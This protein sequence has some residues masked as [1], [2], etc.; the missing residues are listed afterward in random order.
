MAN[1]Y[2]YRTDP[3]FIKAPAP[4]QKAYLMKVDPDFAKAAPS[5]QAKYLSHIKGLDQPTRFEQARTGDKQGFLSA[6][7]SD[8]AG[9]ASAIYH[10]P[11][12]PTGFV[13]G[14]AQNIADIPQHEREQKAAGRSL[15]YRAVAAAGQAIGVPTRAM[16]QAADVGDRGAV[17]GHAVV[18]AAAAAA[19]LAFEGARA[20]LSALD[21]QAIPG[22]IAEGKTGLMQVLKPRPG[23]G[24]AAADT[25]EQA[26][27]TAVDEGDLPKI[28][29]DTPLKGKGAAVIGDAVDKIDAY[30]DQLWQKGHADPIARVVQKNPGATID[31]DLARQRVMAA[32]GD[33]ISAYRRLPGGNAAVDRAVS[34]LDDTFAPG[35]KLTDADRAVRILNE[36][37]KNAPE[38][39]G[40]IDARIHMES[41]RAL[42]Q[43]IDDELE[44][45][46]E[47]GVRNVNQRW[48]A[49]EKIKTRL[50]ERY[51]PEWQKE[52]A[53]AN[54][55]IPGWMR[56]YV[57][58]HPGGIVPYLGARIAGSM[59]APEDADILASAAKK[60]S[61]TR[62]S[63]VEEDPNVADVRGFRDLPKP[64]SA[65]KPKL[66]SGVRQ[67]PSPPS[68][69]PLAR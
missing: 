55:P 50:G 16:E 58:A 39:W 27:H 13:K 40:P 4:Q 7:G 10:I 11:T 54:R 29:K 22:R 28:F 17:L 3:E 44:S 14:V 2:D 65:A 56:V 43:G 26:V 48:G 47:M 34:E 5:D 60:L 66:P 25:M 15:P 23:A 12:N 53:K 46:G 64:P 8:V 49:L 9:A 24:G 68:A 63:P 41:L 38:A 67:L 69:P 1:G 35:L 37:L 19:P 32:I 42:R 33:D 21:E 61:K 31:V 18:P 20:G 45:N 59:F 6:V 36:R 30:Q 62:L 57:L 52:A 51:W